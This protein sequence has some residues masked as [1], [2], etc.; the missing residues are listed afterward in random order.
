MP[1]TQVP[2]VEEEQH[3]PLQAC[4][5]LQL[6]VHLFV[7]VSQAVPVGQSFAL[8]QP[9]AAPAIPPLKQTCPS[10]LLVQ[11]KQMAPLAPHVAAAVSTAQTPPLQQEPSHGTVA[12]Q[13]VLHWFALHAV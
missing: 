6:V 12:L 1:P 4:V 11:S 5:A 8:L 3:P 13:L 7:A 9:Q 10:G 2:P